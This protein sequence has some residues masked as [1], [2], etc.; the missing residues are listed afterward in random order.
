MTTTPGSNLD[1]NIAGFASR[2][3][4]LNETAARARLIAQTVL[5][6][7]PGASCILYLLLEDDEG[8]CWSARAT[9]GDGAQPDQTVRG[10]AGTLASLLRDSVPAI[11]EGRMLVREEYAHLNIRRTLKALLCL[12]LLADDLVIGAIEI[13]SF[14]AIPDQA[15]LEELEPLCDLAARALKASQANEEERNNSLN[16]I[17]RL[18]QFYDIEKVFSSTLEM[19]ELLPIIGGKMREMLEC[20][21]VN[22]WLLQGDESLLLMQQAGDDP[23]TRQNMTQKAGEGIAA[24]VSNDG[25]PL[26][27][28]DPSDE[29][30]ARRNQP[31]EDGQVHSIMVVPLIDKGSLVGVVEAINRLDGAPFDED[32]LF[33]LTSLNETAS[34]ALHNASLLLAERKVEV[35]EMLVT[36]SREI[37]STLNLERVLQTIVDAPQALIPYERAAIA[38]QQGGKYKLSAVS[39]ITQ[40]DPDAPDIAPLND[41]LRWSLLSEGIVDVRQHGDIIDSPREETRAKFKS[42]F[43]NS[44]MRAFYAIPLNDDT[45]RVGILGLVSSDPDFLS[46]AHI[47]VLQVIA[48]QATVALRNAQM[49]KEVPFISVLQPM[50]EKKRKFMAL[51]K[52]RRALI[53]A[54]SALLLIF[55]AAFPLP[56][57]VDGD[58]LVAPLHSAQIQ[59]EVEGVVRNV[60]VHEGDRV[61]KGQVVAELADWDFRAMLA[62]AQAKLQTALLEM[63]HALATNDGTSAG[64]QRVQADYWKSEVARDQELLDKTQLRSPIDGLVATPHVENMVGRRLQY[65]DSLAEVVDTSRAVVDVAIDDTDAALLRAGSAA[66]VKLNSFPTRTFHGSVALVSPKGALVGDARVFFARVAIANPDRAIR[67]GMEGR[68]KVRVGWYPAGYVLFRRPLVW[69]YSRLWS[70]FGI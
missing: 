5:E 12:P 36:V 26:L 49:Y 56:L 48:G 20:S 14:D 32:D 2:L 46:P 44:G 27:I 10:E 9:V 3:L 61:S 66:S 51:E 37:T 65:G 70:W 19:D 15:A 42:Y 62:Q 11:Y 4:A 41:A 69:L 58:A 6:R 54:A 24:D 35:L 57:R 34:I 52:R 1:L 28:H 33:V 25:E 29:R 68:G 40:V 67:A 7:F 45:G 39:G 43:E 21:A 22:L 23:T 63:N 18:T 50:L 47:E 13:L 60:Y 8:L 17:T 38:L 30:L 53:L 31:V 16:S 64:V 55:L 59:P